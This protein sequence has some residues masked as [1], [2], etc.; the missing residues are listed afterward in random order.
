VTE[1][2]EP[3][4]PSG[5]EPTAPGAE[6]P[7]EP[8]VE[9]APSVGEDV[10]PVTDEVEDPDRPRAHPAHPHGGPPGQ[11]KKMSTT[12]TSQTVQGRGKKPKR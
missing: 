2:T 4:T 11:T 12:D 5:V 3:T 1:P 10:P 8:P 7:V 6:P 9:P